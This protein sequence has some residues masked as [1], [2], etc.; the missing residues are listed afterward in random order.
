[1]F[2][3]KATYYVTENNQ[4]VIDT[5]S[6]LPS[7][8][9]KFAPDIL[10]VAIG[11]DVR[12]VQNINVSARLVN[13]ATGTVTKVIYNNADVQMRV[14]S[15]QNL[16]VS[17]IYPDIWATIGKSELDKHHSNV[18][19]KLRHATE[20]FAMKYGMLEEV[21]MELS[22]TADYWNNEMAQSQ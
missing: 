2:L 8:A 13:S 15:L 10:C 21:K 1:M 19:H 11:C 7:K 22:W 14:D 12:L 18:E 17:S 3:C 4:E 5:L 9:Y 16:F 6:I 20:E